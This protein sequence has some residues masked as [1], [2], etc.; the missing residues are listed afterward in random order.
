MCSCTAGRSVEFVTGARARPAGS[1]PAEV[2]SF[3][4]RQ[5][6][7]IEITR[8]LYRARVVT[9]TG[10]AGIGKTRLALRVAR[11][12]RRA[13]PAGVSLVDLAAVRDGQLV[14]QHVTQALRG[15]VPVGREL[16]LVL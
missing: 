8:L 10:M 1:L 16:L 2:T 7:I 12:L 6:E 4:G 3:V 11:Q 13:F 15:G 9:R 14:E 5:D